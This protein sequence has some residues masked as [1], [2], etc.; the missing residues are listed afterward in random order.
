M[1][2]VILEGDLSVVVRCP[3]NLLI[4][5][6]TSQ[7]LLRIVREIAATIFFMRSILDGTYGECYN[8]DPC[9]ESLFSWHVFKFVENPCGSP[10]LLV[11][12]TLSGPRAAR[13]FGGIIPY[14]HEIYVDTLTHTEEYA[15]QALQPLEGLGSCGLVSAVTQFKTRRAKTYVFIACLPSISRLPK[16]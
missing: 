4:T 12:T 15:F 8:L 2:H 7:P 5:K 11:G 3:S 16:V 1:A 9:H 6:T 13:V 10:C 14:W